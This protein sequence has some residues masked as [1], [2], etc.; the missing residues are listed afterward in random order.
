MYELELILSNYSYHYRNNWEM[1]RNI[2]YII[3]QTN[4]TKK[5][6]PQ[7]IMKFD[8]DNV[9]NTTTKKN[10]KLS[11]KDIEMFRQ[12]AKEII[13]QNIFNK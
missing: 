1:T 13:N 4:S 6:K 2:S 11:E 10:E 8:W 5:L 7:D 9:S 12:K 3:A